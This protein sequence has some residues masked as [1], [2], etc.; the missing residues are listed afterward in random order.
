MVIFVLR[1][2]KGLI[3]S[4]LL[5]LFLGVNQGDYF[6]QLSILKVICAKRW[7]SI[8]MEVYNIQYVTSCLTYIIRVYNGISDRC[9]HLVART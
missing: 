3:F 1:R 5:V 8:P 2:R 7:V 6:G 4:L 9:H